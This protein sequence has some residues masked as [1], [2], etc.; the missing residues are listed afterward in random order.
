MPLPK[1]HWDR[2]LMKILIVSDLHYSLRQFDWLVAHCRD[3]DLI[4]IAGDLMELASA[5]DT[6]TQA[7]VVGQYFRKI[8]QQR[9]LIVCS[10]NHD[11]VEEYDGSRSTEW[12]EDFA[13]PGLV[14]DKGVWESDEL[15]IL[16]LPWWESEQDREKIERWLDSQVLENDLRPVFWVNHA[17]PSGTKTSWNGKRDL[18]DKYLVQWIQKWRP[19]AVFSGHIHNAPYYPD[20]SWIDKVDDTVVIN[21]GRQIGEK[22]ATVEVRLEAGI[23]VWC[24]MEGCEEAAFSVGGGGR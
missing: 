2:T 6:D 24:G 22:P 7:A 13:I 10:G 1:S 18:G 20:G 16:A 14:V 3:H 9:P 23:V 12:L 15:R 8:A 17:P 21:G 4:I 5:V 19:T 11:L